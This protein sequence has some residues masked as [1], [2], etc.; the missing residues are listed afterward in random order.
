MNKGILGIKIGMS[1]VFTTM[2]R[3]IPVTIIEAQP[4]VVTNVM[5]S[6]KNG[7]ASLQLAVK[8]RREKTT[9]KPM[10]GIFKKANTTPKYFVKEIRDFNQEYKVG[11]KVTVD[12]FKSGEFVDVQ[13]KSKGKGFA[14]AIKRHNQAIGPKSHG[15][16]GGSKPIRQTGSSGD[17]TGNR[18]YKGTTMPGRLGGKTT[19]IQNLE[20]IEAK[21]NLILIKGAVPGPK[22]GFVVITSA[23]KKQKPKDSVELVNITEIVEKN[24]LLEE[25]KKF[26]AS[27]DIKMTIEEMKQLIDEAKLKKQEEDAK[28]EDTSIIG[29]LNVELKSLNE[30]ID[31]TKQE[32]EKASDDQI[33]KE[34]VQ[35]KLDTLEQE[36]SKLKEKIALEEKNKTESEG[37]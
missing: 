30:Q 37:E 24:H 29:Q 16:G 32:L 10:L 35:E 17:I 7:Y 3:S 15:G 12:I 34:R 22:R 25:A 31:K 11:D 36:V 2:G 14:G 19:T 8:D 21:D 6:S 26:G 1:Q 9:S 18:V 23:K 27:L 5:T 20:V 13:S 33:K 4:N 28:K